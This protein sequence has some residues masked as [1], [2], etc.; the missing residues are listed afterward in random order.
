MR[1]LSLRA[2]WGVLLGLAVGLQGVGSS[3]LA[4]TDLTLDA[5][6]KADEKTVREILA[7]FKLAEE[8]L[9]ARNLDRL[10]A[11]YSKDYAY[12]GLT[13]PDLQ[14][15]WKDLFAQHHRLASLHR[16]SRIAATPGKAPSAEVTCTGA[17]WA[18]DQTERR[19]NIDS[20]FEEV[21]YLVYESAAWRI[22]GHAGESPK[23]MRFGVAP[24]PL[25]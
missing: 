1:W 3:A 7:T 23:G 25:F 14:K 20:W 8:A 18:T 6:I 17:L 13:K 2:A 9:Q 19:V 24:H 5:E 11:L 22:R 10:M 15:I 16:L 4:L 21:H 12:H